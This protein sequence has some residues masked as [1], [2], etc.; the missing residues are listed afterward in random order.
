MC[1]TGLEGNSSVT[2]EWEAWGAVIA[3][4]YFGFSVSPLYGNVSLEKN[5]FS[6][7]FSKN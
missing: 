5:V 4:M 2:S 3:T 7:S 1:E 6:A